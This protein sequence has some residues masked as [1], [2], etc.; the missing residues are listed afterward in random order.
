MLYLERCLKKTIIFHNSGRRYETYSKPSEML[1][2]SKSVF[3]QCHKSFYVNMAQVAAV[4]ADFFRMKDGIRI[5]I[6]R[7]R[8]KESKD[9]FHAYVSSAVAGV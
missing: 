7:S 9:R 2:N 8:K 6:S 4:E 5:P 3:V 1:R